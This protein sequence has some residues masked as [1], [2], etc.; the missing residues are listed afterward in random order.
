MR[1]SGYESKISPA[2]KLEKRNKLALLMAKRQANGKSEPPIARVPDVSA[3]EPK[4]HFGRRA[5]ISEH[6]AKEF[7]MQPSAQQAKHGLPSFNPILQQA[8]TNRSR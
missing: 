6:A 8:S 2:K 3:E 7:L 5:T 4:I 1:A